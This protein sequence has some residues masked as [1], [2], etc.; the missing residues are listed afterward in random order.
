[1]T[2]AQNA[3]YLA[4]KDKVRAQQK[5]SYLNNREDRLERSKAY[6]HNNKPAAFASKLARE[7]HLTI[8]RYAHML[9][10][11]GLSC[12]IC[13]K[14]FGD[15]YPRIDHDHSCCPK[16]ATSCGQCIRGLLCESC[17]LALGK[18]NDDKDTLIRAAEY[19]SR[20]GNA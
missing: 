9:N 7:Y 3:W 10:D 15:S 11:Q 16:K 14:N 12:A 19:V 13:Y 1:M 8:E 17:N 18:F 6:Y 20:S 5:Q 2:E 4:N